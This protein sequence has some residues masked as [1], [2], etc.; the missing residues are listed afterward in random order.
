MVIAGKLHSTDY[1]LS[2]ASAETGLILNRFRIRD[3]NHS[4]FENLPYRKSRL[5]AHGFNRGMKGGV[6]GISFWGW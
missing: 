6:A 2:I 1:G 3:M 5:K 4:C